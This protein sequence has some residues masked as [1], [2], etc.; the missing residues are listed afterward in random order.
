MFNVILFVLTRPELVSG[1]QTP[2]ANDDDNSTLPHHS[3]H[4]ASLSTATGVSKSKYGHLPVPSGGSGAPLATPNEKMEPEGERVMY[5]T[6]ILYQSPQTMAKP[7][8]TISS[9]GNNA[10]LSTNIRPRT[11]GSSSGQ[12]KGDDD[13]D[14]GHLP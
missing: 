2:H 6:E 13:E 11:G 8:R 5:D 1:H 10:Y 3:H 14:Y 9:G 4:H 7:L 12:S